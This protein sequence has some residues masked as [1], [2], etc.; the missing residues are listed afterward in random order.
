MPK[1]IMTIFTALVLVIGLTLAVLSP[2]NAAHQPSN[3]LPA[4][5]RSSGTVPLPVSLPGR[6]TLCILVRHH[7]EASRGIPVGFL[8]DAEFPYAAW[9]SWTIYGENVLAVSLL[10]DQHI[11]PDGGSTNPFGD[12]KP[13]FA[14]E[15][16][17]RLLLLPADKPRGRKI[18]P[19]LADI[20]KKNVR[21]IPFDGSR[22]PIAY[23]VSQALPGYNSVARAA[24]RIPPSRR[25]MPSTTRPAKGSTAPATT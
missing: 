5:M 19:S 10:S 14:P 6:S 4:C 7:P 22:T 3:Q 25:C 13:V 23:R 16:H 12:G 20:P 17:Y 1:N 11:V 24:R 2:S 8:V 15:R 9:F 18:A 21:R